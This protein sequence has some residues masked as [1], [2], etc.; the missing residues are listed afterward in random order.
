MIEIYSSVL[1]LATAAVMAAGFALT[2]RWSGPTE[3]RSL[4]GSCSMLGRRRLIGAA[5]D[6]E[7]ARRPSSIVHRS[8]HRVERLPPPTSFVGSSFSFTTTA[9]TS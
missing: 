1:M 6:D 7:D 2:R 5:S 9:Q 8:L 3:T 4:S